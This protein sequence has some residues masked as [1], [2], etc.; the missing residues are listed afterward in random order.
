M[1][2]SSLAERKEDW[3][4]RSS[5]SVELASFVR[6]STFTLAGDRNTITCDHS[7]VSGSKS[8]LSSNL[9]SATRGSSL[10]WETSRTISS[11]SLVVPGLTPR[12][13][14]G[15]AGTEAFVGADISAYLRDMRFLILSSTADWRTFGL[16]VVGD[17]ESLEPV[18]FMGL[19]VWDGRRP[20]RRDCMMSYTTTDRTSVQEC[21]C[22]SVWLVSRFGLLH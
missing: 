8:S 18:R 14:V 4:D 22:P 17:L 6:K 9:W 16:L 19:R 12:G 7:Q 13:I 21:E 15:T 2:V 5:A 1:A 11:R 3:R 20:V 10:I